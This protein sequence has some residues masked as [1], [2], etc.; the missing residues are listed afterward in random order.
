MV[1]NNENIKSFSIKDLNAKRSG[2]SGTEIFGGYFDEEYLYKLQGEEGIT[3][4]DAMRRSDGQVKMLLSVI[5]NPI[6][7][8]T[9]DIEPASTDQ[10]DKDIADFIKDVLFNKIGLTNGKKRK[11]FRDLISEVLTQVEF[12]HSV[13][14]VVHKVVKGDKK[15]GDYIGLADL[16]FRHQ[17][18]ILEWKLDKDGAIETLRQLVNGDQSVDVKIDGRFLLVFSMDKEGDNYE[19]ISMLRPCYG[20]W[21]RKNVFLK[22]QAIGVERAAKGIPVGKVPL[23]AV[24]GENLEQQLADF[25]EVL[26]QLGAHEKNG[27]VL[28]AG[29][30]LDQLKITH[31]SEKLTKAISFEDLQMAKAFLANFMELGTGGGGGSY[32]LGS[33]LSDIFL[34]GIQYIGESICE[35]INISLIETLVKANFGEQDNYPKLRVSGINDKAGKELAEIV[36]KLLDK[37]AVQASVELQRLMH[38]TYKLND[39]NEDIAVIDEERFKS[40]PQEPEPT[41]ENKELSDTQKKKCGHDL[42]IKDIGYQLSEKDRENFP[43]S[44]LIDDYSKSLNDLMRTNLRIRSDKMLDDVRVIINKGGSKVRKK[45]LKTVMPQSKAYQTS[46]TSW[47]SDAIEDVFNITVN[48]LGINEDNIKLAESIKKTPKR[49]RD[50][51]ISLIILVASFQ[52]VDIEKAVYFSF[53]DNFDTLDEKELMSEIERQ[54]DAYHAKSVIDVASVNMAATVVNSTRRETFLNETVFNEIDSFIFQN[55]APKSLI[56]K[57]LNNKVLSKEEFET[58]EFTPPLHHNCKSYLAAQTKG[59]KDNKPITDFKIHGT[60]AEKEK[61]MRTKTL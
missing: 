27:I 21:F 20:S 12:G 60:P 59:D 36:A 8:A 16:G 22:L 9:W 38:K 29:F 6:K 10:K 1:G 37:D 25:Q 13:F 26:D 18:S 2:T 28:P 19:G 46:L 53:N 49:L 17:K 34:N 14:E 44:A 48:E 52:D 57:H 55:P 58:S 41:K 11:T 5:K 24:Q 42:M 54:V 50:K 56:C 23:D 3:E 45:V 61:I 4:F 47:T 30:E 7:S 43:I 15:Y 51:L 39:L 32:A 35:R 33:D 31:D 40:P